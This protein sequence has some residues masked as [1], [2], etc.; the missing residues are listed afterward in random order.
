VLILLTH[1]AARN[2]AVLIGAILK[3][4]NCEETAAGWTFV[5]LHGAEICTSILVYVSLPNMN[6]AFSDII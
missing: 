2:P 4:I 5:P 1:L 3:L 6:C